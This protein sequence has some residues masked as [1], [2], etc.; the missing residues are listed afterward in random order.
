MIR[1]ELQL[2]VLFLYLHTSL[3]ARDSQAAAALV[4][5]PGDISVVV[6]VVVVGVLGEGSIEA[7]TI[8]V[9]L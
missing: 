4:G 7:G 2:E 3:C 8:V 1:Y 5:N 9:Q 6:V